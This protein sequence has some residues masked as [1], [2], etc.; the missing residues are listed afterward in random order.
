MASTLS[1]LFSST[2]LG[3]PNH[4]LPSHPP[5]IVVA[6]STR[7]LFQQEESTQIFR[8]QG[9]E[10]F[11]R[12]QIENEEK[13]LGKGVAFDLVRKLALL[14][15]PITLAPL[16]EV[17]ILSNCAPSAG[18]RVNKSVTHYGLGITKAAF[19]GGEPKWPY[20]AAFHV[21]LFLEVDEKEV[22]AAIAAGHA[23]AKLLPK[24]QGEENCCSN[25]SEQIRIAFDFDRVI[26]GGKSDE[27]WQKNQEEYFIH[28]EINAKEVIDIGPFKPLLEKMCYLKSIVPTKV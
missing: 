24:F 14:Q 28:E 17:V 20:L 4:F 26:A 1:E 10:A 23:A 25:S 12:Y 27:I 11:N 19:T 9:V 5:V 2:K 6:V 22:E 7:A 16:V 13:I 3:T 15:D 8:S 18:V 21:D